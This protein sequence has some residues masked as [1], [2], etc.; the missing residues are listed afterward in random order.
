MKK[1]GLGEKIYLRIS[2]EKENK[3]RK[4]ITIIDRR[5]REI[6]IWVD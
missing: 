4:K 5:T 3:N 6:T 2:H 1:V